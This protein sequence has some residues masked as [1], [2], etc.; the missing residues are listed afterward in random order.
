[1]SL[2]T[3]YAERKN[4]YPLYDFMFGYFPDAWLEVVKVA[5]EGNKQ[6]NPGTPVHWERGKSMD[7]MNT[8]FRHLFDHGTGQK[9]DTDGCRHLAKTVWRLMAQIQL[10]V[11]A[12]RKALEETNAKAPSCEP[13]QE[14]CCEN[15]RL[16]HKGAHFFDGR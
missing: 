4:D 1:M 7:Q 11:E 5:V 6:H 13:P 12:E 10:E 2:P 15:G 8:A 14:A 9:M 3:G 16:G